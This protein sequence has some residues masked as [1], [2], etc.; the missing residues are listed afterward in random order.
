[1][2]QRIARFKSAFIKDG[3]M[4]C[5]PRALNQI[6][7]ISLDDWS[8]ERVCDLKLEDRFQINYICQYGDSVWCI[9]S[10][11]GV[12]IVEYHVLTGE[13]EHFG[14]EI[15]EQ[16]NIGAISYNGLIWIIPKTI[17]GEMIYF[18]IKEKKYVICDNWQDE[19]RKNGVNGITM[20]FS[21]VDDA[22]YLP[23]RD[24]S[25]IIKFD[26]KKCTVRKILLPGESGIHSVLGIQNEF[27][28]TSY[29]ERKIFRWKKDKEEVSA[30]TCPYLQDKHYRKAVGFK[31][32]ILLTD[33]ETV[34]IFDREN[35]NIYPYNKV[36]KTLKSDYGC[37]ALFSDILTYNTRYFL[38][39]FNANMLLE[40]NQKSMEWKGHII[41]IP[42]D[43]YFKDYVGPRLEKY[44]VISDNEILL[45]DYI[46]YMDFLRDAGFENGL[47]NQIGKKI[48]QQICMV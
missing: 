32:N 40:Y 42:N 24:E 26:L 27:Y 22:V 18:D 47:K 23:M 5:V 17:P 43:I 30:F 15:S 39:S 13:I 37:A 48:Y 33:G 38:I 28:A 3:E 6:F 21:L 4:W 10:A 45:D 25:L 16:E 29:V 41:K 46:D 11:K 12:R 2:K 20:P 9:S 31:N 34:D 1:V 35:N 8:I 14:L 19:C 36:P 44:H 7:K